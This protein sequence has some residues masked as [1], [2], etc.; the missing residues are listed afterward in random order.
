MP[1]HLGIVIEVA[2]VGSEVAGGQRNRVEAIQ[3]VFIGSSKRYHPDPVPSQRAAAISA[4]RA[5]RCFANS[6][7]WSA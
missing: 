5:P 7:S 3:I 1:H 4:R 6:R 2:C